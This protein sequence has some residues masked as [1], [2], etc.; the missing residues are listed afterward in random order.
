MQDHISV[1]QQLSEKPFEGEQVLIKGRSPYSLASLYKFHSSFEHPEYGELREVITK[2]I[3]QKEIF[4]LRFEDVVRWGRWKGE[5]QEQFDQRKKEWEENPETAVELEPIRGEFEWIP[6]PAF[7]RTFECPYDGEKVKIFTGKWNG[8]FSN[9][10]YKD[11]VIGEKRG[12]LYESKYVDNGKGGVK[13]ITGKVVCGFDEVWQWQSLDM[14]TSVTKNGE[15]YEDASNLPLRDGLNSIQIR[16]AIG[17]DR[18][19]HPRENEYI[20]AK[21][22]GIWVHGN[23][24]GGMLYCDNGGSFPFEWITIWKTNK[25][26]GGTLGPMSDLLSPQSWQEFPD[27]D[28]LS[29]SI[30]ESL[31]WKEGDEQAEIAEEN[32]NQLQ[33][34]LKLV[35]ENLKVAHSEEHGILILEQAKRKNIYT[36]PATG[37]EINFFKGTFKMYDAYIDTLNAWIDERKR[38]IDLRHEL[39]NDVDKKPAKYKATNQRKKRTNADLSNKISKEEI[40]HPKFLLKSIWIFGDESLRVLNECLRIARVV[41]DEDRFNGIG[42]IG[43]LLRQIDF[44]EGELNTGLTVKKNRYKLLCG[45]KLKVVGK[46]IIL[47]EGQITQSFKNSNYG[48]VPAEILSVV[49]QM[50]TYLIKNYGL[51]K[52]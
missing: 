50:R 1:Q 29:H 48:Q 42:M 15:G 25:S 39:Q 44:L 12:I 6:G 51:G 19:A 31:R 33:G 38:A 36:D 52:V 37:K 32:F 22:F 41:N 40:E 14:L 45:E 13:E 3:N 7:D 2:E 21:L 28:E 11:E 35:V 8:W 4:V 30:R 16:S 47:T 18:F 34:E 43:C 9:L 24:T 17:Q 46:S 20:Y 49:S 10:I 5:S 27:V 26:H 23:Y